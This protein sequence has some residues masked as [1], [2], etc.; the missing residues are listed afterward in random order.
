MEKK[1]VY[2]CQACGKVVELPA[3]KK[4]KMI[5][6]DREMVNLSQLPDCQSS[7]TAEDERFGQSDEP[8]EDNVN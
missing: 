3:C 7:F 4:G 6:C 1:T 2:Q 5:C 8:C